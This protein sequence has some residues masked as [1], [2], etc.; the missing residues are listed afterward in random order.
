MCDLAIATSIASTS[1][2]SLSELLPVA[3]SIGVDTEAVLVTEGRAA[4]ATATV[5][6]I[7]GAVP[8]APITAVRVQVT[9]LAGPAQVQPLP[10][11]D[12]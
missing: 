1:V 2:G 12:T 6:V 10:V 9:T 5:S 3:V 4:S 11:A 8:P 7:G